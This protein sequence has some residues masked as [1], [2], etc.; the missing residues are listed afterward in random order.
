MRPGSATG[1]NQ[2][3]NTHLA[4]A[5]EL[6]GKLRQFPTQAVFVPA[7]GQGI[8]TMMCVTKPPPIPSPAGR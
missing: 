7:D 8:Y 4:K 2:S 6:S 1:F 3:A 5:T